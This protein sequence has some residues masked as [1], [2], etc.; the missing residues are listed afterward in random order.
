MFRWVAELV[1]RTDISVAYW[2]IDSERDVRPDSGFDSR[3]E[4]GMDVTVTA[5][6]RVETHNVDIIPADERSGQVWHL[7]T[8]WFAANQ[9]LL[10]VVTGALG[11][12]LGL[13]LFWAIVAIVVGNLF[14]T[15]FMAYHSAQGPILGVTQMI[16]SR[17]QFGFYGGFFL[18]IAAFFLQ[19]GFFASSVT[20]AGEALNGL[21][22]GVSIPVGIVIVSIPCLLLA[23]LGYRWLHRWQMWASVVLAAV[24]ALV[25]IQTVVHAAS[26]GLPAGMVSTSAPDWGTFLVVVSVAA[27]YAIVW[28]P[29]VSDYSRYLPKDAG[30]G[31]CFGWTY[32]GTAVSCIWLEV[33]GSLITV[34]YPRLPTTAALAT[35]SGSWI[36]IIMAFSLVGAATTNL[37]SGMLALVTAA[38]TWWRARGSTMARALGILATFVTG[39]VIALAGYQSFVTNF[40]NFLLVLAFL[41]VPWTAV[42]LT[43]FYIV[44]HGRYRP[45]DFFT[46]DGIY[47]RWIWQALTAYFIGL[48]LQIPFINQEFYVGPLVS[49]LGGADYSWI[50]GIVVPTVLYVALTR[51][52]PPAGAAYSTTTAL[53]ASGVLGT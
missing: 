21:S 35:L 13:N 49:L 26:S 10:T 48:A 19:F 39:F 41:F 44:R 43:D 37:Y 47:G 53:P 27:T 18:F 6:S 5:E 30:I 7:G 3:A 46:A 2:A 33:L 38:T 25:T 36:L 11:I 8:F 42:N 9:Q 4:G 31:A 23:V 1:D 51:V 29:F 15:I 32:A 20:L 16:Q 12:I 14:G 45:E 34:L 24:F 50:V 40:T 22:A 28:A 17:G 52:W